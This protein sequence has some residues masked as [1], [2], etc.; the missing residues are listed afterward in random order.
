MR[1]GFVYEF[2]LRN[3]ALQESSGAPMF[4]PA[5]AYYTLNVVPR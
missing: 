2:H 3:L 5:E 4:F 1:A